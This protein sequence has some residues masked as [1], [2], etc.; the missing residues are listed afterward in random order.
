MEYIPGITLDQIAAGAVPEKEAIRLGTQLAQGLQA[1]H[2]KGVIH[3]DL[4]PSN[5]RVTPDRWIKSS[6]LLFW[7]ESQGLGSTENASH[8]GWI[9]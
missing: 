4:K 9:C 2:S 5:L 3:R 8:S 7:T 6:I 1:A